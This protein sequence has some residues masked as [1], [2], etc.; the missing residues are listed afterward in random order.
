VLARGEFNP[1]SQV[2]ATALAKRT[3]FLGNFSACV[4]LGT[5]HGLFLL[6]NS[7]QS[8]PSAVLL[9]AIRAR[10]SAQEQNSPVEIDLKQNSGNRHA[11]RGSEQKPANA[12][13]E[14]VPGKLHAAQRAAEVEG[15]K[16]V[17]TGIQFSLPP[18]ALA[19]V[20]SFRQYS[21]SGPVLAFGIGFCLASFK[22]CSGLSLGEVN[23]W[24]VSAA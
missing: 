4:T 11:R 24:Q 6:E 17:G 7:G 12:P 15:M 5:L 14:L 23:R 21:S 13:S 22:A 1:A 8:S 16:M 3:A 19:S 9:G 2:G 20:S 10:L 18:M